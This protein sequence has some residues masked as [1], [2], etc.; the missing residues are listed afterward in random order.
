[1]REESRRYP[2]RRFFYRPNSSILVV[3]SLLSLLFSG[4]ADA[5]SREQAQRIHN[6]IAGSTL[7]IIDGQRHFSNVEVPDVFNIILRRGLDEMT[8]V[9]KR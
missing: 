6:R 9:D 8:T 5:G 7:D 2:G 4:S 1:M 3:V